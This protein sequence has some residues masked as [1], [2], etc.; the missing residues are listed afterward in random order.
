MT[1]NVDRMNRLRTFVFLVPSPPHRRR[2]SAARELELGGLEGRG[3]CLN[4]VTKCRGFSRISSGRMSSR[5][6]VLVQ[7][8]IDVSGLRQDEFFH[9]QA[10]G[11]RRAGDREDDFAFGDPGDGA[12]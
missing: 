6:G 10:H 8:P 9:G 2:G 1:K 7:F 12:A 5:Q 11:I 4:S 3:D